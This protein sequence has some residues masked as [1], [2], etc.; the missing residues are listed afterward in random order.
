[1]PSSSVG[2]DAR[3]APW[4]DA[5]KAMPP[6]NAKI[7]TRIFTCLKELRGQYSGMAINKF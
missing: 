1:M 2:F 5:V 7:S 4:V 3:G 6:T